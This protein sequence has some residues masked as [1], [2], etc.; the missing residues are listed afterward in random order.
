MI[1]RS[2]LTTIIGFLIGWILYLVIEPSTTFIFLFGG[3]GYIIGLF[4]DINDRK[5]QLEA[6]HPSSIPSTHEIFHSH[7]L[8]EAVVIYSIQDNT[9]SALLDYRIEAKPENYRLSVLK[10]LQEF[11]FRIIEDTTQTFFSLCIEYPEFNYSSIREIHKQ[12]TEFFY[13]IEERSNDFQGAIRKLIPGIV[14]NTV[15]NP[16]IF[17]SETEKGDKSLTPSPYSSFPSS[18]KKYSGIRPD[19]KENDSNSFFTIE[20]NEEELESEISES[21]SSS[22]QIAEESSISEK[23]IIEDLNTT[24]TVIHDHNTLTSMYTPPE[25]NEDLNLQQNKEIKSK[26]DRESKTLSI[27]TAKQIEDSQDSILTHDEIEK[28]EKKSEI[29]LIDFEEE[30]KSTQGIIDYSSLDNSSSMPMDTVGQGIFDKIDNAIKEKEARLSKI[31][32]K[33]PTKDS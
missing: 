7:E 6:F 8:P 10:N 31:K 21:D 22:D 12:R 15:Q 27:L 5:K 25:E 14:I 30:K 1:T 11:D 19:K 4:L 13:D 33:I 29:E 20:G 16:D 23:N 3:F 28:D 26:I 32:E 17:G 2:F 9:T 24:P 18:P